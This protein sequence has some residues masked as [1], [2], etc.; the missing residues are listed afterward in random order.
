M[1][2]IVCNEVNVGQ[3]D[4]LRLPK[5]SIFYLEMQLL[6]ADSLTTSQLEILL[7]E[8]Y[9]ASEADVDTFSNETVRKI[10]RELL[11]IVFDMI[12]VV[13]PNNIAMKEFL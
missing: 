11:K 6:Y 2:A 13:S 4:Y 12:R 10:I 7:K 3:Q 5:V 9:N 1:Y 8:I